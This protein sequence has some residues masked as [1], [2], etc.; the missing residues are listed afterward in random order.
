MSDLRASARCVVLVTMSV[1]ACTAAARGQANADPPEAPPPLTIKLVTVPA[2][3]VVLRDVTGSYDQHPQVITQLF[4]N[5]G[6]AGIAPRGDVVGI[7]LDDP[8]EVAEDE[9]RWQVAM[10]VAG[11]VNVNKPY[12][13]ETLPKILAAEYRTTLGQ[14]DAVDESVRRWMEENDCTASRPVRMEYLDQDPDPDAMR[15]RVLIPVTREGEARPESAGALADLAFMTGSWQGKVGDDRLVEQWSAAVGDSMMGSFQWI[16]PDG[17][18][19]YELMSI[20]QHEDHVLFQLRHFSRDFKPWEDPEHPVRMR[21]VETERGRAVFEN[22]D[23][24]ASMHRIEFSRP[25]G[26]EFRVRLIPRDTDAETVQEISFRA[27]IPTDSP[28]HP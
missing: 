4:M 14:L 2:T 12:R 9:L 13:F 7:Y 10:P 21:L 11:N 26:A 5:L 28:R 24:T 15:V 6:M 1:S 3:P 20:Q 8:A 18:W 22:V 25:S 19:M 23:E 16:R 17:V 27:V